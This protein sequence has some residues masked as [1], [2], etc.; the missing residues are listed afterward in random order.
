MRGVSRRPRGV[1]C[2]LM[3]W[4]VAVLCV[5]CL[6]WS[7]T[8]LARSGRQAAPS[9]FPQV[10][11]INQH[12]ARVW[13][14]YALRPSEQATDGEWCRRLYLDVIG[15]VPSVVELRE[16]VSDRSADKKRALVDRLLYEERYRE[17]FAR[18]WTT[19][20]T[21]LLIG[22]SG[23]MQRDS[24][25]SRDGMQDY[26]RGSFV[27]NKPYDRLVYELVAATG[28]TV[29]G[30]DGYNGATNFL[31]DK[32][33][34]ENG[35]QAAAQTARIFLG[36]QVQ[37]TQCH[38]HPF[39]DWK[40]RKFWEFNAF[41]RQTRAVRHMAEGTRRLET[42]ELVDRDFAGEGQTPTEA[43]IYYELRSGELEVAYPVFVDGAAIPRSGLVKDVV[44]REELGRLMV[45]SPLLAKTL[46]N[47]MWGHFLG[48][49]FTKPVDDLGPHN[50]PSHPELLDALADEFRTSSFDIKALIRW[51]TLSQPY[52]LSS[53]TNSTN[54]ALDDPA[55]GE[56]PKFSRFYLRQMQAEQLYESLLVATEAHKS[57]GDEAGQEEAK[58]EWLRQ[59]TIAFGNDEGG[60]TTT[61][62]GTIP[63]ALVMFN[64]DFIRQ[65][66]ALEP[67]N[68]LRTV[69]E[70]E[71]KPLDKMNYLFEAGLARRATRE[72]IDVANQLLV[73]RQGNMAAAMQDLW[74]AVLNSNEFI[75][76]H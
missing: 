21:N 17:E 68:L 55:L 47:R 14:A 40:Q 6:V 60:E 32:V 46:V 42:A 54:V 74:W 71:G 38:N 10:Q 67:G 57:R 59:F 23:G 53:R 4:R 48:F 26:L 75:M 62:N 50:P 39:N 35:A 52:G 72:E 66:V 24:L 73:A 19:I 37:C 63:Q 45:S 13:E 8:S 1:R 51:L 25:I 5:L 20:W 33:N 58:R 41:F 3:A 31:I 76:N 49:G 29:P 9:D 34:D 16:F 18:N 11:L 15:R 70:S 2:R 28:T 61:F 27:D 56:P 64:G 44:R 22:R 65:A 43:E 30:S 7:T 36:L 69:A 12:I